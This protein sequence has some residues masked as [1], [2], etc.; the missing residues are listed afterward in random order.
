MQMVK[1][2]FPDENS[3]TRGF[4]ELI[5]K[6]RVIC[7]PDGEFLLPEVSLAILDELGIP[8]LVLER[9]GLDIGRV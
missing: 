9:G 6:A 5:Q 1:I 4:Y 7:L 8:Y 2:R 3:Q